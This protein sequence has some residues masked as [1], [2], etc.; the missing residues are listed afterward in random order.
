M[1]TKGTTEERSP[2]GRGDDATEEAQFG[3]IKTWTSVTSSVRK[4][5]TTPAPPSKSTRVI[6]TEA[7]SS[8]PPPISK[9]VTSGSEFFVLQ[10]SSTSTTPQDP[11]S[12]TP[13]DPPST[14]PQLE[15]E[16]KV[17]HLKVREFEAP[18][19]GAAA[20]GA[21]PLPYHGELSPGRIKS[22]PNSW[23]RNDEWKE[24][25][26][27]TTNAPRTPAAASGG[28]SWDTS[29]TK[30][31]LGDQWMPAPQSTD[32]EE[33][34]WLTA[35]NLFSS[36]RSAK[37]TTPRPRTV[38]NS[39]IVV[40][41]L[42]GHQSAP[43]V[44]VELLRPLVRDPIT[45]INF[46]KQDSK[47]DGDGGGSSEE[48]DEYVG[49]FVK[50][51][52]EG[53]KRPNKVQSLDVAFSTAGI[54]TFRP[55]TESLGWPKL[56]QFMKSKRP[57]APL[58]P[59]P[60]T[61]GKAIAAEKATDN[62][63]F[64]RGG[65]AAEVK[66]P[67]PVVVTSDAIRTKWTPEVASNILKDNSDW[68]FHSQSAVAGGSALDI[69]ATVEKGAQKPQGQESSWSEHTAWTTNVPKTT[70]A[71]SGGFWESPDTKLGSFWSSGEEE[72]KKDGEEFDFEKDKWSF[73]SLKD[74][75]PEEVF[76][77]SLSL[78][79]EKQ[80][81]AE[82]LDLVRKLEAM[83]LMRATTTT[84]RPTRRT[85][86]RPRRKQAKP[87]TSVRPKEKQQ[88]QQE[89]QQQEQGPLFYPLLY[90]KHSNKQRETSTST[91]TEKLPDKSE[92]W[93]TTTTEA[94]SPFNKFSERIG[95]SAAPL[96][97]LSAATLVYGAASVLPALFGKRRRRRRR[98]GVEHRPPQYDNPFLFRP[99]R[100]AF[101]G[102]QSSYRL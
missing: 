16:L 14:T 63:L 29:G 47:Y 38:T 80:S 92:Y 52:A 97:G 22:S 77:G 25:A 3:K 76:E 95:N 46:N 12:T 5:R 86:K 44:D 42:E 35:E 33:E 67:D 23:P 32:E 71:A 9:W 24:H 37:I 69:K 21:R 58:Y 28:S 15:F 96:A 64:N 74:T 82:F 66:L 7:T 70:A 93:R 48:K 1:T 27:R 26:L 84:K 79:P 17:P 11:P 20:E 94:P 59:R 61:T 31:N 81:N 51:L 99:P 100:I 36:T 10:S 50:K 43:Q 101:S 90:Q 45:V 68:F 102:E 19:N 6:T 40:I 34:A 41:P 85:T 49:Y 18:S 78:F 8:T 39:P 54:S 13:K 62:G 73:E 30:L 72:D 60:E 89:Q 83:S 65:A 55:S 91:P 88:Q 57:A 4:T 56:S 53:T 2:T 75:K 98:R 87:N